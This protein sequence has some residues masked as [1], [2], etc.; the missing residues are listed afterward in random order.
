M[1]KQTS[2]DNPSRSNTIVVLLSQQGIERSREDVEPFTRVLAD[3]QDLGERRQR[4][5]RAG[6]MGTAMDILRFIKEARHAGATNEAFW[7]AFLATH[8]GRLSADPTE[9][10]SAGRFLRIST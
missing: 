10:E 7:R 9:M 8:F 5:V 6:G 1:S 4:W 3:Q 2:R